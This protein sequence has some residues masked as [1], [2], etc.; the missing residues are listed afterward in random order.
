MQNLADSK[1]NLFSFLLSLKPQQSK[2]NETVS[3]RFGRAG[4]LLIDIQP[5]EEEEQQTVAEDEEMP[6]QEED[7]QPSFMKYMQL[8]DDPS[9]MEPAQTVQQFA[10]DDVF[11]L[12]TPEDNTT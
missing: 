6:D 10:S 12:E 9:M 11:G 8:D 1:R 2:Q 3:C 7:E 4:R 5:A